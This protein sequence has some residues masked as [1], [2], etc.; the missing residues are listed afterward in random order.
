MRFKAILNN[1]VGLHKLG[2][3]M[4]KLGPV[5]IASFATDKLR[6]ITYQDT[7]V[8]PQ[9]WTDVVATSLFSDYRIESQHGNEINFFF[10]IPDLL[11]ITKDLHDI[12][13]IQVGLKRRGEQSI[14]LFRWTGVNFVGSKSLEQKELPIE[15]VRR[16]RLELIKE[17]VTIR[18]PETYILLPPLVSLTPA[19][20]QF[21]RLSKYIT[22][23]ANMNGELKIEVESAYAVCS[24]HFD[25]L[26]N[27]SLSKYIQQPNLNRKGL[28]HN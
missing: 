19:A 27:P 4:E 6:F 1:P 22:I 18:T 8:G 14:I 11:H 10:K 9:A 2:Q 25:N 5:C 13:R 3:T 23:A 15:L 21:R 24:A 28:Q 16:D 7:A 20:E 26:C 12:T 17:P